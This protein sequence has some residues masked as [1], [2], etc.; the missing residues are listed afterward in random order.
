[1]REWN[2]EA[3]HRVSNP[4][5]EWGIGVLDRLRLRGDELVL[6]IGCGTGRLTE[7]LVQRLPGGRVLAI[8]LSSNM[9]RVARDYLKPPYDARIQLALADAAALPVYEQ[10]DA[11]FSTATF[12]WVLDH[13]SLFR[14]L[15]DAL[16]PGGQL[17][18]QCG[19]GANLARIRRRL[20]VLRKK[21]E[22]ASSFESWRD[23]WEFADAD[24]TATRLADAG[25]VEIHTSVEWSPVVFPAAE[26]F[27]VFIA[28]VICR[29][30]LAHIAEPSLR[31]RLIARITARAAEDTPPFELDYWRLNIGARRDR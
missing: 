10:A 21:P 14:S 2:A 19:G 16:K 5:F 25:S 3:Y 28:N 27:A 1:M 29:P 13:P 8:D 4:Q 22:F 20:D 17:I 6:D 31:D 12:H 30:Y 11:I 7:E 18:A 24:T 26:E 15:R 23:P 9:L